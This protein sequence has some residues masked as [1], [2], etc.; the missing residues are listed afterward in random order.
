MK[1]MI[2]MFKF[3]MMKTMIIINN[4]LKNYQKI[5]KILIIYKILMNNN[6]NNIKINI[7]YI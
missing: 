5:M 2:T 7:I 3:Y 4:I 6:N 1:I